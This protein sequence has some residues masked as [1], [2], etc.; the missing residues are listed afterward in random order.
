MELPCILAISSLDF[1][2]ELST[3]G[4]ASV[5]WSSTTFVA[6][7]LHFEEGCQWEAATLQPTPVP[8]IMKILFLFA[9]FGWIYR[10]VLHV[11][12]VYFQIFY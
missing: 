10:V 6:G 12:S 8:P 1:E 5:T 7:P 4:I 3:H 2:L 11:Y 9:C